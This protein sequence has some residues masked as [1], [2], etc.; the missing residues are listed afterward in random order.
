MNSTSQL[1]KNLISDY[2]PIDD[3]S[4]RFWDWAKT[5]QKMLWSFAGLLGAYLVTNN[6]WG[7]LANFYATAFVQFLACLPLVVL[8]CLRDPRLEE[9]V[10]DEGLTNESSSSPRG[11]NEDNDLGGTSLETT[12]G[13]R[14]EEPATQHGSKTTEAGKNDT[15][16]G[17]TQAT[18]PDDSDDTSYYSMASTTWVV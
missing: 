9:D 5:F 3:P 18:E 12:N 16:F 15:S 11:E 17:S 6:R 7:L 1:S 8:Y 13:S 4:W 14:E 10:G 2:V